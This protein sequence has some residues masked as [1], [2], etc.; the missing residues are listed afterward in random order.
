MEEL[1]K[2]ARI[3]LGLHTEG[4][5]LIKGVLVKILLL[6]EYFIDEKKNKI[7][8]FEDVPLIKDQSEMSLNVL[9]IYYKFSKFPRPRPP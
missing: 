9:E 6:V 8:T 7:T 4:K 1:L 5:L 3:R 2:A